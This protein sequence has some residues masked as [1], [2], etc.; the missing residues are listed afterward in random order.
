MSLI[1]ASS[2]LPKRDRCDVVIVGGGHNGLV[3]AAYLASAGLSCVV[4]ERRA[5]L[6]GAVASAAPFDGVDVRLSR[7]S[8]LVSLLPEQIVDELGL[9]L[10]LQRRRVASY[11]PDPRVDGA[12]GL[13]IDNDDA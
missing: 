3:A 11:T 12:R 7:Y 5:A 4:L 8:Y 13:L 6:G 1:A 9:P 2:G 10:R